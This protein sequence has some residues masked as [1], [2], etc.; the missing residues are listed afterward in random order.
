VLGDDWMPNYVRAAND[1]G[2]ERVLV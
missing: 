1:G 2:I